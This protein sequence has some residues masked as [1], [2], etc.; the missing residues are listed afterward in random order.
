[1]TEH[2][3]PP[4]TAVVACEELPL[5]ARKLQHANRKRSG[6]GPVLAFVVSRNKSLQQQPTQHLKENQVYRI[7]VEHGAST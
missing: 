6:G 1:M 2:D 5:P 7:G 4:W 3:S